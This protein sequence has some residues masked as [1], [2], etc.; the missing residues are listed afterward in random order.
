MWDCEAYGA[1]GTEIGALCFF[2]D[3]GER[4]CGSQAECQRAMA[5]ERGRIFVRINEK[6]VD[7]D[8][9]AIY[10]ADK[11][12]RPD[13]LLGGGGEVEDNDPA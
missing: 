1:E 11:F 6:A 13:Q 4:V 3:R 10:L 9:A 8:Q 5:A 2:A 12:A 7:G